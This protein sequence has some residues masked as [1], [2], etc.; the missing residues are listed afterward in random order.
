MMPEILLCKYQVAH[1]YRGK[2][3]ELRKNFESA[4]NEL[5]RKFYLSILNA[6]TE[7][8]YANLSQSEATYGKQ[9]KTGIAFIFLVTCTQSLKR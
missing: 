1:G 8:M 4:K 5:A 7:L 9:K 2:R 6:H 3:H